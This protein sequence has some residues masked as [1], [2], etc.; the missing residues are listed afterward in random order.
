[1]SRHNEARMA[2]PPLH[3]MQMDLRDTSGERLGAQPSMTADPGRTRRALVE[4]R[5]L[6]DMSQHNLI[7][8]LCAPC[9]PCRSH[10]APP[11]PFPLPSPLEAAKHPSASINHSTAPRSASATSQPRAALCDPRCAAPCSAARDVSQTFGLLRR[12][13]AFLSRNDT[14][15]HLIMEYC[16]GTDLYTRLA[17]QPGRREPHAA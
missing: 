12:F 2:R 17:T 13:D 4:W 15:F 5:A 8:Q 11:A 1:M 16:P 9:H 7:P 14:R 3:T 6:R 10:R